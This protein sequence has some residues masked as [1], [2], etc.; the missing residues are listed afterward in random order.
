MT[1]YSPQPLERPVTNRIG[2]GWKISD[3]YSVS[4]WHPDYL[5]TQVEETLA[6]G[7]RPLPFVPKEF[8]GKLIA[9]LTPEENKAFIFSIQA[10]STQEAMERQATRRPEDDLEYKLRPISEDYLAVK[11][12]KTKEELTAERNIP[13]S[14]FH[15]FDSFRKKQKNTRGEQKEDTLSDAMRDKA[16][17]A[18]TYSRPANPSISDL[19]RLTNMDELDS[20]IATAETPP[21][22]SAPENKKPLIQRFTEWL[23]K[24]WLNV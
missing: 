3:D 2:D 20:I 18:F 1:M 6:E 8:N 4:K 12:A 13:V 17:N 22:P 10:K 7:P 24:G 19:K 23:T 9:D 21:P 15:A 14:E 16:I 11:D 5:K